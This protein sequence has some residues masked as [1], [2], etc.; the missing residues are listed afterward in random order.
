M[1]KQNFLFLLPV[2]G[3][4]PVVTTITNTELLK[5]ESVEKNK[6][7]GTFANRRQH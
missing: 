7:K 3:T 1:V 6:S 2:E 4:E 5:C